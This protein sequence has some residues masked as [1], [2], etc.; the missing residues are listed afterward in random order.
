[1][2]LRRLSQ[3]Q[4]RMAMALERLQKII[5]RSGV[6][7]RRKAEEFIVAGRVTVNGVAVR[8]LGSKADAATDHIRVD[9]KLLRAPR[10]FVY[11]A[12]N[13]PRGCV[14]TRSDPEQ[15]PTV[16]DSLKGV[17]ERVYPVGRL[18]FHTEGLLLLTNDGEFA[19]RIIS[20]AS[21]IPKTY[22]AKVA[23]MPAGEDLDKLRH[24]IVLDRRRTLPARIRP[25][26]RTDTGL[27]PHRARPVR[28]Q[29]NREGAGTRARARAGGERYPS[30]DRKGAED[31]ANPW[32]EVIL[33]EGR[34]N[35]IRR[36]F[37]R[38]GHPVRKLKRVRIGSVSLGPLPVGHYRILTAQEVESLQS[39]EWSRSETEP[40]PS[41]AKSR[42]PQ[43]SRHGVPKSVESKPKSPDGIREN[44]H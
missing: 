12:L 6:A 7:S 11:L 44:R 21:G 30:R 26:S 3:K 10:H 23:G 27:P 31:S 32:F 28:R 36:M 17:K 29:G 35:Q 13:K 4:P 41:R 33:R 14:T 8:E 5:A 43:G 24:G 19:N 42:E 34:Q 1:M 37:E 16:M 15:R 9:G 18:D 2:L 38:I 22:W 40:R 39:K 25:L 20:A